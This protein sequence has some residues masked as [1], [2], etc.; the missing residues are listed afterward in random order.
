[1]RDALLPVPVDLCFKAKMGFDGPVCLTR[2]APVETY[3]G[4]L[5]FYDVVDPSVVARSA[6]LSCIV[7]AGGETVLPDSL[8][9]PEFKTWM[10]DGNATKEDAAKWSFSFL[11]DV[12]KVAPPPIYE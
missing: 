11:C 6:V 4:Q 8:T 5:I 12:M 7:E 10:K 3:A 2:S 9:L 1:M